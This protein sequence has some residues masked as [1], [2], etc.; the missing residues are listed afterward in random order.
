[1]KFLAA[2]FGEI[3]EA[4]GKSWRDDFITREMILKYFAAFLDKF[5]G[6]QEAGDRMMMMDGFTRSDAQKL[7]E[8]IVNDA[9]TLARRQRARGVAKRRD[10]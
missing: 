6:K 5:G 10:K 9:K 2:I 1:M 8:P 4:C 7:I 3:E